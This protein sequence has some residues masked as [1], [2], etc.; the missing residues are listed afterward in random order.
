MLQQVY[1]NLEHLVHLSMHICQQVHQQ[2]QVNAFLGTFKMLAQRDSQERVRIF[3]IHNSRKE[4]P[5]KAV[6]FSPWKHKPTVETNA[7]SIKPCKI[8][9]F[10]PPCERGK[11]CV[12]ESK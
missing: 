6:C 10:T 4:M 5:S 3:H 12:D 2:V 7:E 1:H 9:K 11:L 8:T